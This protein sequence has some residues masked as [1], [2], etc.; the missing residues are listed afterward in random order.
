MLLKILLHYATNF[1]SFTTIYTEFLNGGLFCVC[2][3]VWMYTHTYI[4]TYIHTYKRTYTH[5]QASTYTRRSPPTNI[6]HIILFTMQFSTPIVCSSCHQSNST[7]FEANDCEDRDWKHRGIWNHD[8]HT[9]YKHK[10]SVRTS[11][12]IRCRHTFIR[13][14]DPWM[15][16]G[17]IM[18]VY[19]TKHTEYY[20]HAVWAQC[21]YSVLN[22]ARHT[23]PPCF[24]GLMTCKM[25]VSD[26]MAT[27][28][29]TYPASSA[30]EQGQQFTGWMYCW[31]RAITSCTTYTVRNL[32]VGTTSKIKFRES[33]LYV[34][35]T[36]T[37]IITVER[38]WND[39]W[40]QQAWL[41]VNF[42]LDTER[43]KHRKT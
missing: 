21:T 6:N 25:F 13:K 14:S 7:N 22:L 23:E 11:Q 38:T 40:I 9:L 34:T 5:T 10:D 16:C 17:E 24:T 32:Y 28:C 41:H 3:T 43:K 37:S 12:R 15:L 35:S 30:P 4:H 2:L 8:K 18:A 31:F 33:V 19:C 20:K 39:V 27:T 42:S 29:T 26:Y 1:H 36:T